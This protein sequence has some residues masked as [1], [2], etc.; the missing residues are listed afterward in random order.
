MYV[1]DF[2][3]FVRNKVGVLYWSILSGDRGVDGVFVSGVI[4]AFCR[5]FGYLRDWDV[6][7]RC[8][9]M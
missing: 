7:W 6:F 8:Y 1:I 5:F 9:C 4:M 2:G 3:M